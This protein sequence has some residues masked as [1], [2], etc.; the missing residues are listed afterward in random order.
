MVQRAKPGTSKIDYIEAYR[1]L[2]SS[3]RLR[4]TT[5]KG[6][7]GDLNLEN[8]SDTG[9][10]VRSAPFRRLQAKAQVFSMARSGAVRT[11]LTHTIEVS[12]YGELIAGP[13][14][15]ALLTKGHLSEDL[16]SPFI[17][18]VSNACLLHDIGNPPFG[19]MGEYAIQTWF[20]DNREELKNIWVGFG[21]LKGDAFDRHLDAYS[22][23]DGNPHGFRIITRLQWFHDQYGL[24]LTLSLLAS[25][26]KYLGEKPGPEKF[27]K[28]GGFFPSEEELVKEIWKKL[29]LKTDT[30]GLPLLRHPLVFL[31]EAADDISY[32]LSDIEDAIE[33]GVVT[34]D[35][36]FSWIDDHGV[37]MKDVK[38]RAEKYKQSMK[39][40]DALTKN[41]AYHTFR[42][43][44]S[45]DLVGRAVEAYLKYEDQILNGEMETSLLGADSTATELL[46]LLKAFSA[47]HVYTSREAIES[48]L[49]GL[50]A[51]K[52]L[53][54]AYKPI[55]KL[56]TAE[57]KKLRESGSIERLRKYPTFALLASLL[58]N[59]HVTAYEW[60]ATNDAD[61][62][63]F[64]R[65]QLVVD[66]VAGMTDSHLLKIYNIVN[67]TQPFGIE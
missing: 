9:R 54:N 41:G 23:F 50:N 24:N 42:I 63:P 51:I 10:I 60:F 25:Y 57:F 29:K 56:P 2:L 43:K 14:V 47:E 1:R 16:R 5:D 27:K 39:K 46:D 40:E 45:G 64:Y 58:P 49:G 26:L 3:Q 28:K 66:Y 61:L 38:Q 53:L 30:K 44:Y 17:K 33:Q 37:S 11:R 55:L 20:L 6:R 22:T 21:K 13:L 52:G 15:Q 32:C 67:G 19:H 35:V 48:E 59:K 7:E 12:N 8:I 65:T 62:E 18:T 36:F 34:E 4:E 31:M